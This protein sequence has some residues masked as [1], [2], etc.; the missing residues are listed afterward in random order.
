MG[1][2][3]VVVFRQV[4]AVLYVQADQKLPS[5]VA[6]GVTELGTAMASSLERLVQ[7][8]QER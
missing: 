6:P 3:P 5:W 2:L 8:D 1:V 7:T 4:S